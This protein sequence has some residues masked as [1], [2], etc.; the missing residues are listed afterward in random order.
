M[1]QGHKI[2]YIRNPIDHP[3]QNFLA[4]KEGGGGS[5]LTMTT[6]TKE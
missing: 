4:G 2:G 6:K 3:T 5:W 1:C